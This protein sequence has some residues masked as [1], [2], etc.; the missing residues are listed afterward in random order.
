MSMAWRK[1]WR[2]LWRNK[3]RSPHHVCDGESPQ[4]SVDLLRFPRA[5][6]EEVCNG[7]GVG[8]LHPLPVQIG[9]RLPA[10]ADDGPIHRAEQ[11]L[12]LWL[13][14]GLG[15]LPGLPGVAPSCKSA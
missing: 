8:C 11:V 4:R 6:T 14:T 10:L 2:D 12:P 1:I 5:D 3:F 13:G 15:F 9:Q 7:A